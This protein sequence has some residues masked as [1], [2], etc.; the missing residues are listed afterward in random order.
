MCVCVCFALL[1]L[2][3]LAGMKFKEWKQIHGVLY[4]L[5]TGEEGQVQKNIRGALLAEIL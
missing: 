2:V 4:L 3:K 1:C 5:V